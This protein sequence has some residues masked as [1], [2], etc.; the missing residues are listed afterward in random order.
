[1]NHQFPALSVNL[2]SIS[3]S[4][5]VSQRMSRTNIANQESAAASAQANTAATKPKRK[6]IRPPLL[7]RPACPFS[8]CN[9]TFSTRYFLNITPRM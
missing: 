4:G 7:H 6:R 1:M 9:Q 5:A 8:G 3:N 2:A